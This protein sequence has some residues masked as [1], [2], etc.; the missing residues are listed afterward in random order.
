MLQRY[1]RAATGFA[2]KAPP[3]TGRVPALAIAAAA[4]GL[5]ST[6]GCAVDGVDEGDRVAPV[7]AVQSGIAGGQPALD[8][9]EVVAVLQP[10]R[11]GL[12]TGTIVAPHA[13]LTAKHCVQNP[14]AEGPLDPAELAIGVGDD[15]RALSQ[16]LDAVAV[17]TTPGRWDVTGVGGVSGALLGVDVAVINTVEALPVPGLAYRQEE[18]DR[19]VGTTVT[20][21]G[22]G[23][24]PEGGNGEKRQAE[25]RVTLTM[26]SS[27]YIVGPVVCTGDSGGPMLDSDRILVG[28][29]SLG[30]DACG[31]NIGVYNAV[32]TEHDMI[33]L[34]IRRGGDCVVDRGAGERGD[35]CDGFDNDCD[36]WVDE[37]CRGQAQLCRVQADC[38]D[39][40]LCE[41]TP[42][43]RI[44]T[45]A[46]DPLSSIRDCPLGSYCARRGCEG[47]CVPG[48]AGTLG[49]DAP[50][51]D[52]RQ[53]ASLNCVDPGDG[54]RRCLW[55]CRA[56]GGHC[57]SG[58]VCAAPVGACGACVNAELLGATVV[59]GLGEPCAA[60]GTCLGAQCLADVAG[61]YCTRTCSDDSDCAD[62]FTCRGNH[63]V[64]RRSG[65][66]AEPCLETADCDGD[67]A[68]IF[69][70]G[71][72]ASEVALSGLCVERCDPAGRPACDPG[73]AC[74][75][76]SL[77]H[78]CR[79]STRRLGRRCQ[80]D[81]ECSS[82]TCR[83]LPSPVCTR[84]CDAHDPCPSGLS[85]R[86]PAGDLR[87]GLG[88]RT[89]YCVPGPGADR[90]LRDFGGGGCAMS[91]ATM[92]CRSTGL[93]IALSAVLAG[94][95]TV[96][97]RRAA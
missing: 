19:I 36:G 88:L 37:D 24:T 74:V 54:I 79:P 85:C 82:G 14:G 47:R 75:A 96:R 39:G 57:L 49:R 41:E 60:D 63:C 80:A 86:W 5:S 7:A 95:R 62:S 11:G 81:G 35:R 69:D 20:V 90:R 70:P 3:A 15:V 16:V 64:R 31:D 25:T 92:G 59:H 91:P 18:P 78:H 56:D 58:E 53:C 42:A 29:A 21:V 45:S 44:C 83:A 77:G 9:P 65:R 8:L 38:E 76:T 2:A 48:V 26:G 6:G 46:C 12:C 43:G 1:F 97:R 67:L 17:T 68:C 28:V 22:F 50:C 66:T 72:A 13:V 27:I 51:A 4:F 93:A 87:A 23:R 61:D 71:A 55:P 94:L 84:T 33:A 34:G 40:L 10:E 89:A 73:F 30:P 52:D 32:H